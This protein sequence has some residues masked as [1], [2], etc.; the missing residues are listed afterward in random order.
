MNCSAT[1]TAIA[2]QCGKVLGGITKFYVINRDKI[3]P[4]T[5]SNGAITEITLNTTGTP[6]QGD[7][8]IEYAF[9]KNTAN[10]VTT[11]NADDSGRNNSFSTVATLE[12]S[13]Q[14]TA[15]R[16]GLQ[17]LIET[18]AYAVYED[19]NH[20]RW[21]MGYDEAISANVNGE[22]GSAP[23]DVNKYVLTVTDQSLEL[24]YEVTMTDE[25]F[26]ALLDENL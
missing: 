12:F 1:L 26:E 21:L 23:T 15:K 24:P 5:V 22:S 16:V 3:N 17:A 2:G 14:E 9:R 20:K 25:A 7:G 13:K 10:V 19:R 11:G 18:D 4:P 6:T 8:F